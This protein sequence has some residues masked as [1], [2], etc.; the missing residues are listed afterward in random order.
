MCKDLF[1]EKSLY[2]NLSVCMQ[3]INKLKTA[4]YEH[5]FCTFV[6]C[7]EV[8]VVYEIR[9]KVVFLLSNFE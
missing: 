3:C 9:R 6:L 7:E 5:K 1:Q 2:L 8:H 4:W